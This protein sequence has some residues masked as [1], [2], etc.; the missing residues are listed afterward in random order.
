MM[1]LLTTADAGPS[2]CET[3]PT[4][5]PFRS[6]WLSRRASFT[7]AVAFV[8]HAMAPSVLPSSVDPAIDTVVVVPATLP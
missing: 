4:P 6:S 3:A 2:F 1:L 8:D 7:V 5:S